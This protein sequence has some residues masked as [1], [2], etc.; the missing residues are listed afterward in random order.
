MILLT[1]CLWL[2]ASAVTAQDKKGD[3]YIS[4]HLG[5]SLP[6]GDLSH[7]VSGRYI[8]GFAGTGIQLSGTYQYFI[9]P[10]I[11]LVAQLRGQWLP[12]K[13]SA[14][15]GDFGSKNFYGAIFT[16]TVYFPPVPPSNNPAFK[17]WQFNNAGYLVTSAMLGVEGNTP[18]T[19]DNLW[20]FDY[21]LLIGA[22]Y[23]RTP[24]FK[25]SSTTDTSV[26]VTEQKSVGAVGFTYQAG[27]GLKHVLNKK[28]YLQLQGSYSG[29]VGLTFKKVRQY[30]AY[31][32]HPGEINGTITTSYSQS[33]VP[34]K[35]ATW[36]IGVGVG[37]R[38]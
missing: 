20:L 28:M 15:T 29:V 33:D 35:P 2:A 22:T 27:I 37:F 10:R 11:S 32:V 3:K 4:F 26:A 36:N 13:K 18:L 6:S 19:K 34:Q 38:L 7:N 23:T 24:H 17:N 1:L 21:N 14:L 16:D 8:M 12:V 31:A 5:P 30:S 9:H 25:G